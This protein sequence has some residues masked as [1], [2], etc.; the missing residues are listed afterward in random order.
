M[1]DYHNYA[2][3]VYGKKL[4]TRVTDLEE[5]NQKMHDHLDKQLDKAR[6][7]GL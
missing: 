7:A 4:Q 6:E 5:E 1:P 3:G 2:N